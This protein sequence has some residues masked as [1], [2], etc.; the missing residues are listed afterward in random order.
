[1]AIIFERYGFHFTPT[2]VTRGQEGPLFLVVKMKGRSSAEAPRL[3][4]WE[5]SEE[6]YVSFIRDRDI[7]AAI[8]ILDDFSFLAK[9]PG[10]EM[11][12]LIPSYQAPDHISYEPVYQMPALKMLQPKTVYGMDDRHWT[13]FDCGKLKSAPRLEWFGASCK[14]GVKNI[15]A[16]TGLRSLLLSSYNKADDLRDAMGSASLDTLK[17]LLCRVKSLEGI[18]ISKKLTV[19]KLDSCYKLENIDALYSARDTLQGLFIDGCKNIKDIS[20]LGELK[21]LTRLTLAGSGKIPSLSFL[22]RLPKLK[23]LTLTM[24]VEDGDLSYC[25]RL[26]HAAIYPDRRHF[27]RKDRDFHH[28]KRPE[29]V[30]GDESVEAWRQH[31]L[32]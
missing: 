27:N 8:V 10:I 18:Q 23:T 15:A 14:K 29:L 26:E 31:V 1:M 2:A 11:L 17:L 21:N 20:V 25:D 6:E 3:S 13:D 16:L 9:C 24:D 12:D 32:R 19:V 5:Y 28:L 22:D 7:K 30:L 4:V